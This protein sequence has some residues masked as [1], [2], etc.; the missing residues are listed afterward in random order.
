VLGTNG[1]GKS[2]LLRAVLGLMLPDRGVVRL[3]GRTITYTD[4]EYRFAR[5]IVAVRGGE[6]IFAGLSVRENL[7]LSFTTLDVDKVERRRRIAE[8]VE[9]F[10]VLGERLEGTASELS[11][12]ERQQ[13]ALARALVLEPDVLVIDELSLGL[14]PI[15]VQSLIEVVERL[16][17][18]GQTMVVVEQSMNLALSVCDRAIYLEKG[19]VVFAGTADELRAR[20]DLGDTVFLGRGAAR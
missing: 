20:G 10:P 11:G 18:K 17:A 5:G 12:G 1:A 8:V 13:L 14:A 2:T 16:R 7:E 6:G 15:V 4:A 3:R 19:H 9:L